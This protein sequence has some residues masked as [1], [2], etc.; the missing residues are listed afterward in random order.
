[1]VHVSDPGVPYDVCY[2]V[3]LGAFVAREKRPPSEFLQVEDC[4]SFVRA[5][6][7]DAGVVQEIRENSPA[8]RSFEVAVGSSGAPCHAF[9]ALPP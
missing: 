9:P 8:G 2:T 3:Q 5:A 1:M 4:R 7:A 6:L